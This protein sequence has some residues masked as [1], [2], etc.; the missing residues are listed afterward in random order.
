[1][2]ACG[3][4]GREDE[5]HVA[6]E[7]ALEDRTDQRIVR[8]AE[9]DRVDTSVLQR[10][11]V[12]THRA[13]R[14]LSVWIVAFDERHEPWTRDRDAGDAR[15]ERVDELGAPP[16]VYSAL[17]R[18]QADATVARRLHGGMRLRRDDADHRH[19][20]LLLQLRERGRGRGV[21]RDDDQLHVLRLEIGA[22]LTG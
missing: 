19:A 6:A 13:L 9:D 5:R 15:V 11:R 21:A 16:A 10:R 18:E 20:Q 1:G 8:A 22:D 4:L 3:L 14:G 2:L 12:L 7:H 17:R